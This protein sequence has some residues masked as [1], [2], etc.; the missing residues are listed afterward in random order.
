MTTLTLPT[1]TRD[2]ITTDWALWTT[3]DTA[4]H[5]VKMNRADGTTVWVGADPASANQYARIYGTSWAATITDT[6]W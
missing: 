2:R 3:P 4:T 5:A 6:S 1:I